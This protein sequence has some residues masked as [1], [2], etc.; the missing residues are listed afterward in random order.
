M[1]KPRPSMAGPILLGISRW[2]KGP[3]SRRRRSSNSVANVWKSS[4]ETGAIWFSC[5]LQLARIE[6]YGA[7]FCS[8][9]LTAWLEKSMS[10][11]TWT[12]SSIWPR[13]FKEIYLSS[14]SVLPHAYS[15]H[16]QFGAWDPPS[17]SGADVSACCQWI[18]I[19]CKDG[20]ARLFNAKSGNMLC[21]WQLGQKAKGQPTRA[22]RKDNMCYE[23]RTTDVTDS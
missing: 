21:S 3:H 20:A 11:A 22:T 2:I 6:F 5:P 23:L 12:F 1:A 19:G 14:F 17:A 18:L 13:S 9:Y 16:P 15:I 4:Q 10:M 7:S 8:S